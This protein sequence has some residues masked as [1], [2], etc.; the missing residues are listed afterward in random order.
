MNICLNCLFYGNSSQPIRGP[1]RKHVRTAGAI[2]ELHI[3][4]TDK[5]S[6]KKTNV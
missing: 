6:A 5:L 1:G 3:T 2:E 4:K